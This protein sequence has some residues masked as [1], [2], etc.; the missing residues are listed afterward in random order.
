M[1][2]DAAGRPVSLIQRDQDSV[3]LR[4]FT[5]TYDNVGNRTVIVD[6]NGSRTTYTYDDKYRLTR[7]HTTGTF[8]RWNRGNDDV[9]TKG[10]HTGLPTMILARPDPGCGRAKKG[11]LYYESETPFTLQALHRLS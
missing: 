1:T 11:N 4:R 9:A 2:Y 8:A 3:L 5:Y 7:D 10:F 6:S